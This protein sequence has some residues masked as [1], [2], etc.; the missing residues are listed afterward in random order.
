MKPQDI[1]QLSRGLLAHLHLS[2][3][4]AAVMLDDHLCQ[5]RLIVMIYD[6]AASRRVPNVKEWCG[7]PVSFVRDLVHRPH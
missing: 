4:E 1:S 5:K 2:A 7:Y 6:A 3:A